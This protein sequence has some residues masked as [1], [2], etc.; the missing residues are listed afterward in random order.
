MV[1]PLVDDA[2]VARELAQRCHA[3]FGEDGQ[4]QAVDEFRYAVVDFR[5]DM[6]RAAAEDDGPLTGLFQV[7]QDFLSQI[8]DFLFIRF[9]FVPG[10]SGSGFDFVSRQVPGLEFF[11]QALA[12]ALLVVE[13]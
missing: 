3:V 8:I 5:V 6:V 13:R 12:D 9:F 7:V 11:R 1:R 4:A 10:G 2:Q